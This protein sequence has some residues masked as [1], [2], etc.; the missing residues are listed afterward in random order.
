MVASFIIGLIVAVVL[1]AQ[2][3]LVNGLLLGIFL[4]TSGYTMMAIGGWFAAVL[5]GEKAYWGS[6]HE[7]SARAQTA[8]NR[9]KK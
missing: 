8:M 9:M 5:R 4:W 7:E 6:Q 2:G 3:H 1:V